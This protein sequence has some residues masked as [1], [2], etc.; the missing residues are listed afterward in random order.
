MSTQSVGTENGHDIS[1]YYQDFGAGQPV[2]LIHGWPLSSRA[3]ELQVP[4]LLDAG[5]RVIT[6]DRRGFGNSSQ[7]HIGFN[8]DTFAAD[9]HTLI[10]ALDLRDVVLIGHSMGGG[11]LARYVGTYGTERIAKI[12]F[13]NAVPPYLA[14]T[15]DNPEGGVPEADYQAL[16][17]GAAYTRVPFLDQFI[18]RFFTVNGTE[19]VDEH[20][21]AYYLQIAAFASPKGTVDCV[22]AFVKTDFRDDI[23]KID[24]PTLI[25]HGDSDLIVPFEISGR[26]T[27]TAI[28]G[29]ELVVLENAPHGAPFTHFSQWNEHVLKFLKSTR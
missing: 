24:V 10:T 4:A 1:V 5:H 9:L 2:I 25:I 13:A 28:A 21:H 18:T 3:W 26:R 19:I 23:T 11:E 12:V 27:H 7:P 20:T 15:D 16:H 22:T 29:S 14:L 17:D 6:Y 8:Y